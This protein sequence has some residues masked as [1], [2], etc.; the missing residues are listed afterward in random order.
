MRVHLIYTNALNQ[1][2]YLCKDEDKIQQYAQQSIH[3]EKLCKDRQEI[4]GLQFRW[5]I[6]STKVVRQYN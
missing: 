1:C 6:S 4:T 5:H 2:S 3:E